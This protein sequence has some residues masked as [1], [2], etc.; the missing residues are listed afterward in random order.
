MEVIDTVW[1]LIFWFILAVLVGANHW[2]VFVL[3]FFN[4]SFVYY[5]GTTL[6]QRETLE[7]IIN[8]PPKQQS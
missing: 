8:S 3:V 5:Q 6:Y 7:R 4:M 1:Q 2:I